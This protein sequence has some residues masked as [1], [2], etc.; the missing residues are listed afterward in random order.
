M[1]QHSQHCT[2][3]QWQ[4]DIFVS[5]G[6][7]PPCPQCGGATERLWTGRSSSVVDDAWPGGK[8][9]E[10]LGDTPVTLYSKSELRRELRARGLE[11]FVRH[12]P[13]PGSDK[14]PHTTNWDVPSQRTLDN[15]R[16]LLERVGTVPVKTAETRGGVGPYA[17]P[18]LVKQ[19][20]EAWH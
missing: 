9:F 13:V 3:C 15:A 7:H 20:A 11:E 19:V 1:P 8:T 10:N 16:A 17:T 14:S 5:V 4:A 6:E 18:E 2:S 12:V